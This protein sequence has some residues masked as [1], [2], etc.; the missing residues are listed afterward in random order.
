MAPLRVTQRYVLRY[1]LRISISGTLK[2]DAKIRP[3][4]LVL[5]PYL[6]RISISVTLKET[7]R[8]VLRYSL[9]DKHEWHPKIA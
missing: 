1:L 9:A 6:L 8:Y 2:G 3:P 7:Q 4:V 5:A